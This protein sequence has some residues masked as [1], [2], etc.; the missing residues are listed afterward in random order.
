MNWISFPDGR[1]VLELDD[2]KITLRQLKSCDKWTII[3]LKEGKIIFLQDYL[4][5]LPLFYN[6]FEEAKFSAE[7]LVPTLERI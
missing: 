1:W 3:I 2:L 7:A 6:T 4:P 5:D